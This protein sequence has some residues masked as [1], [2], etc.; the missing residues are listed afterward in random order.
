M[1]LED[2]LG[3]EHQ[4]PI[5]EDCARRLIDEVLK[6]TI[7][8]IL[9]IIG[10]WQNVPARLKQAIFE[11]QLWKDWKERVQKDIK[12]YW[13]IIPQFWLCAHSEDILWV[14]DVWLKLNEIDSFSHSDIIYTVEEKDDVTA[15]IVWDFQEKIVYPLFEAFIASFQKGDAYPSFNGTYLWFPTELPPEENF[16]LF[17][18]I[19]A[20]LDLGDDGLDYDE[21]IMSPLESISDK[22]LPEMMNFFWVS[23]FTYNTHLYEFL[24]QKIEKKRSVLH[25]KLNYIKENMGTWEEWKNPYGVSWYLEEVSTLLWWYTHIKLFWKEREEYRKLQER[26]AII[27]ETSEKNFVLPFFQDC[28]TSFQNKQ[29]FP[30]FPGWFLWFPE[31]LSPQENFLSLFFVLAIMSSKHSLH[32][33]DPERE[34]IMN[35]IHKIESQVFGELK[36]FLWSKEFVYDNRLYDTLCKK[37]KAMKKMLSW[38]LENAE[39]CIKEWKRKNL[40]KIKSEKYYGALDYLEKAERTLSSYPW[41]ARIFDEEKVKFEELQQ[42]VGK[43]EMRTELMLVPENPL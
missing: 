40:T 1:W 5:I 19:H 10:E 9:H 18:Y 33:K 16:L 21:E 38:Q 2:F 11:I 8:L 24:H 42:Q 14:Y 7:I 37:M 36:R 12:I 41:Y 26:N 43:R 30:P 39:R 29:L 15:Y 6:N 27:I 23:K 32:H 22:V 34:M 17:F 25:A 20:I 4:A 13:W 3:W 31:Q 28:I 35:T